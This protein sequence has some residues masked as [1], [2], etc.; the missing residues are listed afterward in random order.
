MGYVPAPSHRVFVNSKLISG[1]FVVATRPS[2][3]IKGVDFIM[4]NDIA[5]GKV[6]PVPEMIDVPELSSVED[7]LS[8]CYPAVF[9]ASVLTRA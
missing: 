6:L 9:S 2:F 8:Q 4:E 7:E 1:C 5:G 3:L